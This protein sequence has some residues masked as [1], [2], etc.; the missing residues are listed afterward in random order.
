[1]KILLLIILIHYSFASF[2][3]TQKVLVIKN[4]QQKNIDELLA[5]VDDQGN[6]TGFKFVSKSNT[7]QKSNFSIS[8]Q[9]LKNGAT[10]LQKSNTVIISLRTA[11]GFDPRYGGRIQIKYLTSITRNA[12]AQK[13]FE[14]FKQENSWRAFSG[15]R[16]FNTVLVETKKAIG[17]AIGVEDLH[18]VN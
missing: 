14:L 4:D 18:F 13:D 5:I 11:S 16:Q 12:Y 15:N 17:V 2:A 10:I 3:Q 7:T 6:L 8:M 9:T 1:M